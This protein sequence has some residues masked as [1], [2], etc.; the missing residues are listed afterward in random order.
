MII[1]KSTAR[2]IGLGLAAS[3]E[4]LVYVLSG[5]GAGF[6]LDRWLGITPWLTVVLTL[7]GFVGGFYRL[8]K[9][10]LKSDTQDEDN[11][12]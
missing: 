2:K 3:T 11:D 5:Y 9:I 6:F 12:Q 1:E 8:Y 10:L 4:M 7:G